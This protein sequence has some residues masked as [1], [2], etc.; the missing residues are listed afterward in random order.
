MSH[1]IFCILLQ[2]FLSSL[3]S[4]LEALDNLVKAS[5]QVASINFT[6]GGG[7]STVS[8]LGSLSIR[9]ATEDERLLYSSEER[10]LQDVEE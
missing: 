7:T 4:V 3:M 10:A 6:D 2:R 8:L 1:K 9:E 5:G